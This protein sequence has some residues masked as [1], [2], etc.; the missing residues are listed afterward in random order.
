M[1]KVLKEYPIDTTAAGF[2]KTLQRIGEDIKAD[3]KAMVNGVVTRTL[4]SEIAASPVDKGNYV[5]SHRVAVNAERTDF[6]NGDFG[7]ARYSES[8]AQAGANYSKQEAANFDWNFGDSS[9]W[10][11]NHVPHSSYVEYGSPSWKYTGP[12]L[13]YAQAEE[14]VKNIY[15]PEEA[16]KVGWE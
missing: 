1:G 15:I 3:A 2:M 13:I 12:Y 6:Y 8:R 11:S 10:F 14:R 9:V 4:D 16:K 5:A 7:G